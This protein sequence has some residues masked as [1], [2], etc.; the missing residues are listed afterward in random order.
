[1][2]NVMVCM[3]VFAQNRIIFK[4]ADGQWSYCNADSV[5]YSLIDLSNSQKVDIP[6]TKDRLQPPSDVATDLWF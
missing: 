4:T 1:M 6:K 2:S 5:R 3:L